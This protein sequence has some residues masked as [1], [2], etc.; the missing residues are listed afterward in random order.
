M[1][2]KLSFGLRTK[3]DDTGNPLPDSRNFADPNAP[4][5]P[6][7]LAGLHVAGVPCEELPPEMWHKLD[8]QH[9]DEAIAERNAGKEENVARVSPV[10]DRGPG[11]KPS[12]NLTEVDKSLAERY[13][14][15]MEDFEASMAPDPLKQLAD[16]YTPD[17]WRPYFSDAKRPVIN[18]MIDG[19]KV[20]KD[21]TGQPVRFGECILTA[22]PIEVAEA[23]Q[24]KHEERARAQIAEVYGNAR[25]SGA[26][27]APGVEDTFLQR[28]QTGE[29]RVR[30]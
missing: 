10:H 19:G 28:E 12:S 1:A 4:Q 25:E 13:D 9:T 18:G 27:Q 3:S 14:F 24:A 2:K 29:R 21:E 5:F 6:P 20:M 26:R 11:A 7:A 22:R 16:Q 15:R 8:R 30:V 23:I 17:G